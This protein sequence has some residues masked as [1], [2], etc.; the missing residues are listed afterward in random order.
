MGLIRLSV[1]VLSLVAAS[2]QAD[3]ARTI[4]VASTTSTVNS[5]LFDHILPVFWDRTGI[6]VRALSVGTGQALRIA[7]HGDADVLFVHDRASEEAFVAVGFGIERYDVMYNDFVLVGPSADPAR[8]SGLSNVA[9]ALKQ[10]AREK[11]PF[12]SRGDD[13]GTHKAE[14]RLWKA[15]GMDPRPDSGSWY[16]ETGSGQGATLN[17]AAGM[18]AYMLTDR[19]TWLAFKNRRELRILVAGDTRLRNVYGLVL[20]N[21]ERHPHVQAEAGQVFIDWLISEEGQS[22]IGSL[23]VDGE[24]LFTPNAR[25]PRLSPDPPPR[26]VPSKSLDSKQGSLESGS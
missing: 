14:L 2:G 24:P 25:P 17:V 4:V 20:V 21:P 8:V 18:N 22:A 16:R 26:P 3:D 6:Q 7:Q 15:A 19:G 13:S 23:E 1:L 5:G 10:I 11:L 9:I 12:A